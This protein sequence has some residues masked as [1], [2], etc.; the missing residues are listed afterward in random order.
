MHGT[1]RAAALDYLGQRGKASS[2][3]L[4]DLV[5]GPVTVHRNG[6]TFQQMRMI[7]PK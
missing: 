7:R 1:N 6:K 4:G 2:A 3:K 5:L